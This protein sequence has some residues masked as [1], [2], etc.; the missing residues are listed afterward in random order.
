LGL[1]DTGGEDVSV[2]VVLLAVVVV[3]L[4]DMVDRRIEEPLVRRGALP[5]GSSPLAGVAKEE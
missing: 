1:G 2:P 3:E 5:S 4:T